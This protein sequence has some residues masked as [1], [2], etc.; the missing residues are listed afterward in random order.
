MQNKFSK[1]DS[2]K[3]YSLSEVK[4]WCKSIEEFMD[5][6][7]QLPEGF[8]YVSPDK[9]AIIF[10]IYGKATKEA[11]TDAPANAAILVRSEL[12]A[13]YGPTLSRLLNMVDPS[14][15]ALRSLLPK[16]YDHQ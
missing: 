11:V 16:A 2:S 6:F 7:V 3:Y 14:T 15:G 10:A 13:L 9:Y 5:K 12:D 1:E 8:E 4:K